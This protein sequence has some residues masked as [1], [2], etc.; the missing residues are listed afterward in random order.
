VAA[1]LGRRRTIE[2]VWGNGAYEFVRRKKKEKKEKKVRKEEKGVATEK[3]QV[4]VGSHRKSECRGHQCSG[5]L[6]RGASG[7]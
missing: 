2:T 5:D 1:S 6:R 3:S 4:G 7:I